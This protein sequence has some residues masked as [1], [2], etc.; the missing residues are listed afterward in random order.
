MQRHSIKSNQHKIV[1]QQQMVY[2]LVTTQKL[3]GYYEMSHDINGPIIKIELHPFRIVSVDL[4]FSQT[5]APMTYC[6]MTKVG[7]KQ[8][9]Q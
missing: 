9:K 7:S 6:S 5:D 1:F 3:N 4:T 8:R 2:T